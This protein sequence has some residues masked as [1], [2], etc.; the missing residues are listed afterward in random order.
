VALNVQV[1]K[2]PRIVEAQRIE[3]IIKRAFRDGDES[4]DWSVRCCYLGLWSLFYVTITRDGET[5]RRFVR[6]AEEL[7]ED[8]RR[9]VRGSAGGRRR[10]PR[11]LLSEPT[12]SAP[13]TGQGPSLS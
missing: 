5:V 9:L 7:E 2:A 1:V 3:R 11:A 12:A 13:Q 6:P 8:V 10:D 4:R